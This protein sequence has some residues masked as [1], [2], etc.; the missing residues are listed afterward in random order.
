MS[1]PVCLFQ[2]TDLGAP[3]LSGT[4]GELIA[5]LDACLI[6]GYNSVAVSSM[7][8]SGSVVTVTTSAPHGFALYGTTGISGI[9]QISG[10]AEA[11][12]NGKWRVTGVTSP[13]VFTFNIGVLTPATPATG[14]I[15]CKRAPAGWEKPYSG[16]NK[17]VYRQPV[18]TN[19]FYL[20]A[21]DNSPSGGNATQAAVRAYE[22]MTDVD[23]GTQPF[24]TSGQA[25]TGLA[26]PKSATVSATTRP[27]TLI[28]DEAHFY[29]LADIN[30]AGS[31]GVVCFGDLANPYKPGDAFH[32]MII[33]GIVGTNTNIAASEFENISN[34][35][36]QTRARHYMA[37]TYNQLG[38]STAFGK[39]GDLNMGSMGGTSGGMTYPAPHDNGL[40]VSGVRVNEASL[41]RG[42][43]PGLYMPLHDQPLADG[44]FT[45][46][47]VGLAGRVLLAKK[48]NQGGVSSGEALFDITGPW[49]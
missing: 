22:A 25:S 47:I 48:L 31:S 7:T 14:S 37:R 5:V 44:T 41:L 11:D 26:F 16:T 6:N 40:Y 32:T 28:A 33:A 49:H 3:T 42:L 18:G 23:T 17:A 4:V 12:Y 15:T 43:M 13:T 24:P 9:A 46:D 21:D 34:V 2:S 36:S 10:A 8:R 27:W 35:L 39:I 29:W 1:S 38:A 45:T 20:R 30:S 19:R